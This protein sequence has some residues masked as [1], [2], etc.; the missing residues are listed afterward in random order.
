MCD[1]TGLVK[2]TV[3]AADISGMTDLERTN[4][5]LRAALILAG[6]RIVKLNFG[7][8]EDRVLPILRRVLREARTPRGKRRSQAGAGAYLAELVGRFVRTKRDVQP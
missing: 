8:R 2:Y 3:S 5:E 6:K 7:R 4:A 1:G